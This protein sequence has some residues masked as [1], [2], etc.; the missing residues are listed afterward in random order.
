MEEK[1]Q[2]GAES[3]GKEM[4]RL[5]EGER[6][7]KGKGKGKGKGPVLWWFLHILAGSH[8][9]RNCLLGI[10]SIYSKERTKKRRKKK[11]KQRE[12]G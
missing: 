7:E 4:K 12:S 3:F 8:S 11:K 10:R 6:K 5:N 9:F 2:A 1:G